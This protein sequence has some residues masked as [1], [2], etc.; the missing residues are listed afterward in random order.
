MGLYLLQLVGDAFEDHVV[1]MDN[2]LLS[3]VAFD[4]HQS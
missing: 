1:K 3:Y 2:P 4:F